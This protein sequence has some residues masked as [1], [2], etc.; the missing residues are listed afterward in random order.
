EFFSAYALG[1]SSSYE[2]CDYPTTTLLYVG[3]NT[4]AGPC[5]APLVRRAFS[6]AFDREGAAQV[7]LSSHGDPAALPVSPLCGD[8]SQTAADGLGYD[9][10]A[11]AQLLS[12]AGFTL[13]EEEGR[14]YH[15]RTPL[16]VRLLVNSD[17][18]TRQAVAVRLAGALESLGV[19]V[20]VERLSWEGYTTALSS[21]SFDLYIGEVRL[22]GDFDPAPLLTGALNYG[23]FQ[24]W[25]LA[26]ALSQWKAA[27]GGARVQAAQALW[28]QF[29]QDAPI[30][31]LCFK[32]GS[33]LMRW[34][35]ASNLQPTRANPYYQMEHWTTAG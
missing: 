1:Y 27:R 25:E 6:R 16:E 30:A 21:G 26:L 13:N 14:L 8:Y 19:A 24:G 32:R 23:R 11:A 9:L 4:A 31:P 20:T 34:G 17:N 22:T 28:E 12:D 35:M 3:F 5:Q 10:E 7:D 29:A 15:R 33:L 2:T 18:D